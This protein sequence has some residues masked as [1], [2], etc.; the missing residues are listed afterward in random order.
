MSIGAGN[1]SWYGVGAERRL[2]CQPP[3]IP[4][5]FVFL[6]VTDK[7]RFGKGGIMY[8][9][10]EG[11]LSVLDEGT[12][13]LHNYFID[14]AVEIEAWLEQV[15][16]GAGPEEEFRKVVSDHGT[17][18]RD[19][20]DEVCSTDRNPELFRHAESKLRSLFTRYKATVPLYSNAEPGKDLPSQRSRQSQQ[21]AAIGGNVVH[22]LNL[23]KSL[24]N[25]WK[26]ILQLDGTLDSAGEASDIAFVEVA[27]KISKG[28]EQAGYPTTA[29]SSGDID[30]KRLTV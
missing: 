22:Q 10:K 17:F 23:F 6:D 18:W 2:N 21:V 14:R 29:P 26:R 1:P 24:N 13:V 15:G 28:L 20:A 27:D 9:A 25:E 11:Q 19:L 5:Q 12:A 30:Q 3:I 4:T 16:P 7:L 8:Q